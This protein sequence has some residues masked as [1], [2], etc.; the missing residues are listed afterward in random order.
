MPGIHHTAIVAADVECS[1]RFWCDGLGFTELFDHIFTGDWPTLFNART[2]PGGQTHAGSPNGRESDVQ[3]IGFDNLKNG[4]AG[5]YRFADFLVDF[6][7][8]SIVGRDNLS[9]LDLGLHLQT[10]HLSN[11]SVILRFLDHE[12]GGLEL[13]VNQVIF[14][15][16]G[17]TPHLV[18]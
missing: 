6:N 14:F 10:L 7:D 3:S 5:N 16:T 9:I 1:K 8:D 4:L 13:N 18:P 2:D 11:L 17:I 12:L 15:F